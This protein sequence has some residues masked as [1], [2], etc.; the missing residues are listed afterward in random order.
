MAVKSIVER[1]W[2]YVPNRPEGD[3]WEWA[4]TANQRGYGVIRM[5]GTRKK[6]QAT[7]VA[8]FVKTGRWVPT[9]MAACH[10]CDNPRCVN[11][12]H[13]FVGTYSDNMR[14]MV[15]KGRHKSPPPQCF[16]R[17]S[18]H[19]SAKLTEEAV[20]EIRDSCENQPKLAAKYGVCQQTIS[21]IRRRVIW[22]HI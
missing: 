7:H 4:G 11:P 3:C 12:D 8:L 21:D 1:F 2:E 5:A 22:A 18:A 10:R 6:K 14:D 15:A 20:R 19:H 16:P 9:G 13:L 17:G